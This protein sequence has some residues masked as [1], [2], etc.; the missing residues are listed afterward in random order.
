MQ[1]KMFKWQTIPRILKEIDVITGDFEIFC[2]FCFKQMMRKQLC[3]KY[4]SMDIQFALKC[5]VLTGNNQN[6]LHKIYF[7]LVTF[8][9]SLLTSTLK[10]CFI[11]CFKDLKWCVFILSKFCFISLNKYLEFIPAKLSPDFTGSCP[12]EPLWCH[13]NTAD[14]SFIF[15]HKTVN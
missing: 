14:N 10:F 5:E 8:C 11:T 2:L 7:V 15:I 12:V 6:I 1:Q 9:T 4:T 13:L 3:A